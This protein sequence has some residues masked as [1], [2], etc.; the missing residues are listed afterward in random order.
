MLGAI[1]VRPNSERLLVD[2]IPLVRGTDYTVDY[3]LGRVTFA[4]PDTLFPRPRQVTV[5]FE[6]NPVFAETPT[7]IFGATAEFPLANGSLN[8]TAIS[9]QQS[10]LVP[11]A[12]VQYTCPDFPPPDFLNTEQFPRCPCR[13]T[14]PSVNCWTW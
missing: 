8:F 11:A 6:E 12:I 2:G 13:P 14:I 10:S 1:Q 7:S 3:D 5:Q 9:Q 4:R